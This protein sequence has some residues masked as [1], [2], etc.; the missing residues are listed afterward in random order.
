MTAEPSF[1]IGL[2]EV[3]A[4]PDLVMLLRDFLKGSYSSENLAFLIEAANYR[5]SCGSGNADTIKKKAT[6]IFDK[7][8]STSSQYELNIADPVKKEVTENMKSPSAST[9][10]KVEG[11]IFKLIETDSYPRFIQTPI[12]KSYMQGIAN[13][14]HKSK[15]GRYWIQENSKERQI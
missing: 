11:S 7:Y 3:L 10:Q 12:Y 8:F 2:A 5:E 13:D 14:G 9:F 15:T 6:K 4:E 1:D